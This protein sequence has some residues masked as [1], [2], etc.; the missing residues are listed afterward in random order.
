[1][2]RVPR[3]QCRARPA[4]VDALDVQTP[5]GAIPAELMDLR[6]SV[7]TEHYDPLSLMP[8]EQLELI[9]EQRLAIDERQRFGKAV[10]P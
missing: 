6:R 8:S 5:A 9:F 2:R 7:A 4:L 10:G 1:M 3:R